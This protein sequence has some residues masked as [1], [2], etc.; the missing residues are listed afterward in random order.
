MEYSA[1]ASAM[2]A[3]EEVLSRITETHANRKLGTGPQKR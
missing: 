3:M 1:N 2:I